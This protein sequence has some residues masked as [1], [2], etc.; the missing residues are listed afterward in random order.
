MHIRGLIT[1]IQSPTIQ[2]DAKL[3][4]HFPSFL[5]TDGSGGWGSSP[6]KDQGTFTY[7]VNTMAADGLAMQ[8]ARASTAIVVTYLFQKIPT[9]AASGMTSVLLFIELNTD[10][11]YKYI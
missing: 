10:T 5:K 9:S 7:T 8:R 4:L 6:L 2:V 11:I 3:G 1:S